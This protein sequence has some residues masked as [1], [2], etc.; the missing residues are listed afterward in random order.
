M[1]ASSRTRVGRCFYRLV[2]TAK[3]GRRLLDP[4]PPKRIVDRDAMERYRLKMLGE[5][6]EVCEE[7]PGTRVHHVRYRSRGGDDLESNFLWVCAICDSRHG[8]LPSE[9]RYG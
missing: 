3:S 9:S 2:A 5:P 4:R 8:D 1:R 6:C 7:R